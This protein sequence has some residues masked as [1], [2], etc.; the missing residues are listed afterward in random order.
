MINLSINEIHTI[1][2]RAF[3][4]LVN[5]K[6]LKLS[7]NH[8]HEIGAK[9]FFSVSVPLRI[10]NKIGDYKLITEHAHPVRA[11]NQITLIIVMLRLS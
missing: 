5:L 1:G 4:G 11:L 3:S 2:S 9:Y 8:I 6:I 10:G 7:A